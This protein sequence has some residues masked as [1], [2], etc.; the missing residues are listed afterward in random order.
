MRGMACVAG[1]TKAKPKA[2][3]RA[4]LPAYSLK[5]MGIRAASFVIHYGWYSRRCIH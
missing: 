3:R 2:E 4:A 5:E 1:R